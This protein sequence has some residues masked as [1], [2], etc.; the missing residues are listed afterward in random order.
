MPKPLAGI[1]V[2]EL[3][4]FIAGPL[5]GTL[6]ADMGADVVKIEPPKGDMARATPP[7]RNGESISFAALNRNKRSLVLDLKRD[8][9]RDIVLKLAAKS[10]VFLEA[11]RPGVLDKLGLGAMQVKAVNPRIIYTSVSGF[12][13]SGPYRTRAGVNLIVEAFSGVLSV[14]GAPGEMPMR[15]GVQTADVFGALFATYATL[16]SLVGAARNGEGR[17]ADVS[18]VEASIAAAAWEAAEYLETGQVPQPMGNRHRLTAPY[19]LFET[20]DKHYL[21]IGTPNDGL[22][23]K[24]MQVLGLDAHLGDPR[25]VSYASRKANENALLPLVEPAIRQRQSDELEAALMAAGVP[26]AR[27]NNF[28]EVFDDPHMVAR[29]MVQEVEHKTLGKMRVARNPVLLDHDG[30]D[31]A[32]PAPMLGEHSHDVLRELGYPDAAIRE[33]VAAGVTRTASPS[34]NDAAAARI[35]RTSRCAASSK[36]RPRWRGPELAASRDWIHEFSADEISEIEQ[37]LRGA[38]ARGKTL[39]TLT[40]EDFPLPTV[41]QR[42]AH[43]RDFLENGKGIYQFRGISIDDYSKDDLRLLYWGLGRHIGTAVSQSKDGDI[44]GDVRNVGVDIHSPQGRGYKSNQ[45]LNFHTDSADVVGLF[46]LCV[47]K[48]GGLSKVASSVAAHNEILRR[49]PDLLD[50]LYQPFYWSWN[51]QEPPGEPPYYRQ[52]IF[53]MQDGKFACRYI[54]GQIDNAQRFAEVPRLTPQQIEA[55]DLLDAVTNDE[56]FHITYEFKPGDLQLLNNHTCFHARTAFEDHPERERRRHLLRMWL[57]VPNSR[58]LSPA[59][60]VQSIRT[61]GPGVVRGGFPSRSGRHIYES[62][63][64]MVD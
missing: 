26:C 47:A 8:E 42:I 56:N 16:A 37:A 61:S 44:L 41:S 58:P 40:R 51:Q 11:Y 29:G 4:N 9:A 2:I 50:V 38:K 18:L 1:R 60:G 31:I 14:T 57:S 23:T 5:A 21:A 48:S 22:F 45:R 55:L 52:P 12:G 63:G 64:E 24:F 53:S 33:F 3:A 25:F 34:R 49:R 27:V 20:S 54:R 32:R 19:Q 62:T 36:G 35:E 28:K 15:P 43:A 6:L 7:I 59:D 10:D 13:Q 17:I 30:P 39:D 46:V